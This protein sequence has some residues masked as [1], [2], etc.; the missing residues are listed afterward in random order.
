[1]IRSF[2]GFVSSADGEVGHER[3]GGAAVPVPVAAAVCTGEHVPTGAE[4]RTRCE[5]RWST[6]NC[7]CRNSTARDL[8]QLSFSLIRAFLNPLASVWAHRTSSDRRGVWSTRRRIA[9][10]LGPAD[11][12]V[13]FAGG[14]QLPYLPDAFLT[15]SSPASVEAASTLRARHVVPCARGTFSGRELGDLVGVELRDRPIPAASGPAR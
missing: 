9:G 5:H 14:G 10:R 4:Q 1:M 7:Q 11:V 8:T 12:A 2:G 6:P 3:C 15:L 13:I